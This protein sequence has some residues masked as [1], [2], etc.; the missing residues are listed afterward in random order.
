[1]DCR[2][3]GQVKKQKRPVLWV[4]ERLDDG[5]WIPCSEDFGK[6]AAAFKVRA[7]ARGDRQA[8][9]GKTR[10]VKYVRAE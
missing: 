1:V 2:L 10:L 5:E 9:G 7:D 8:W 3:G 4:L 6:P